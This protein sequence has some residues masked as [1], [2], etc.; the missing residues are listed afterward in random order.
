[1]DI[2][3]SSFITVCKLEEAKNLLLYTNKSIS[4]ISNY[5]CFSSQSHFQTV[6]KKNYGITPVSFRKKMRLEL[7]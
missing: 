3:L 2:K 6:F 4:N 5:L 7:N 1:M